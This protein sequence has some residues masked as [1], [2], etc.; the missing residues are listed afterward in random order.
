MGS[1][2]LPDC[3]KVKVR[4]SWLWLFFTMHGTIY[5]ND[6]TYK[7]KIAGSGDILLLLQESVQTVYAFLVD[8]YLLTVII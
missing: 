8:Y 5:K 6:R 7:E 2:M 3:R 4:L 1:V